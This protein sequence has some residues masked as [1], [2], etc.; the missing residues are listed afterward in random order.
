VVVPHLGQVDLAQRPVAV[1]DLEAVAP[2]VVERVGDAASGDDPLQR[3]GDR[4]GEVPRREPGLLRLRVDGDDPPGLVADQVDD[5][6]RHLATALV[7]LELPEEHGL[8]ADRE[9]AAAPRLVEERALEVARAVEHVDLDERLA[10]AGAAGLAA[11]DPS[12]DHRL[13]ADG[14]V[15]D[16]GLLGAVD[17]AARVVGDEVVDGLDR[18][19]ELLEAL[20]GLGSY[21][22]D[23]RDLPALQR[24]ERQ[25][26][27]HAFE[28]TD[29]SRG[30]HGR[31]GAGRNRA[32]RPRILVP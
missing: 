24:R 2:A 15:L 8:G 11:L 12:D 4:R 32:K 9:L 18:G 21:A 27:G 20:G 22:F 26:V 10:V 1:D 7:E 14:E 28:S 5:R 29:R 31:C 25:A 19:V 23:L 17:V 3:P 30:G 16:L 13:L 6:V